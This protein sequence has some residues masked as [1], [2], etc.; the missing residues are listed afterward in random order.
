MIKKGAMKEVHEIEAISWSEWSVKA[1]NILCSVFFFCCYL[2]SNSEKKGISLF[3]HT[4][5]EHTDC[6]LALCLSCTENSTVDFYYW[7][8]SFYCRRHLYLSSS[9]ATPFSFPFT[10]VCVSYFTW[11]T[12]C[13]LNSVLSCT[14]TWGTI[15][16]PWFYKV[17]RLACHIATWF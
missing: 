4:G 12:G 16:I 7:L 9:K 13:I 1:V 2:C 5:A 10:Q 6:Y 8:Y 3:S 11:R 14:D 17:G 15:V